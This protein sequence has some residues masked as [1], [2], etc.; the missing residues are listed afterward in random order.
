[1][2]EDEVV[3]LAEYILNTAHNDPE[4]DRGRFQRLI[5]T[6]ENICESK[7]TNLNFPA[8]ILWK[9]TG[10][11]NCRCQHCWAHLGNEPKSEN[12]I[13]LAHEIA[14]NRAVVVSLS[15]GEPLLSKDLFPI[16]KILKEKNVIVEILTNGSLINQKWVEKYLKIA[17]RETDVVQISLDGS[18]SEL[19]DMQRTV[20]I[21]NRVIESIKL[22]KMKGVKVRVSFTATS[23]N[24]RDIYN[25]Y[26]L[27][28]T[29]G[30]D[31]M[32]I[33]PVFPLRKG[34]D[35][36]SELDENIYLSEVLRC[37]K[38]ENN[39]KTRVQVGFEF[40]NLLWKYKSNDI[41]MNRYFEKENSKYLFVQET[42]TSVQIDAFGLAIPGPE[43][44]NCHSAGNVYDSNLYSVWQEGR[45]W[46]E[47][48]TGRN[49]SNT[50]CAD[51][52]LFNVCGGGNA[53]LAHDL[54]GTINAPDGRCGLNEVG[55]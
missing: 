16:Y 6:V 19:H 25:T 12:L 47:L 36:A 5:G 54:Y 48:R 18:S 33:T 35:I 13:K 3:E 21:F 55:I 43:Y 7:K 22:L 38:K 32:S 31:V 1:M 50:K 4:N 27:C 26:K 14:D 23:I 51:C 2:R 53:K 17:D 29:L 9:I 42:N 24:Q 46:E 39:T 8:R 44:E 41:L 45:S 28:D 52:V 20:P 34:K 49:F 10:K 37:K 40:Q 15:G 30:V 11:C